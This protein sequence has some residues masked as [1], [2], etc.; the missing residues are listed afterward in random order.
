MSLDDVAKQIDGVKNGI[1]LQGIIKK[2]NI[3]KLDS[4]GTK[5]EKAWI[6]LFQDSSRNADEVLKPLHKIAE[7]VGS[8]S[9]KT[10]GRLRVENISLALKNSK[11]NYSAGPSQKIG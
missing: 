11:K 9:S 3:S 5:V 4:F 6:S 7:M 2:N 1:H 8:K 10:P